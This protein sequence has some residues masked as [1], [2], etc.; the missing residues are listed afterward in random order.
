MPIRKSW[1][2]ANAIKKVMQ[3]V[4]K[5]KKHVL[6]ERRAVSGQL[7]QRFSQAVN[8]VSQIESTRVNSDIEEISSKIKEKHASL[9][10]DKDKPSW[11]VIQENQMELI[12][13][14]I[15][16]LGQ[17][18][19]AA[20]TGTS[21][22]MHCDHV[23]FQVL[24]NLHA[25]TLVVLDRNVTV[26]QMKD[27]EL[28]LSRVSL[29]FMAHVTEREHKI[30][31]Q[32]FNRSRSLLNK[33]SGISPDIMLKSGKRLDREDIKLLKARLD[34]ARKAAGFGVLTK[35]EKEMVIKAV[36]LSAGHWYKCPNGHVY[37]IGECGGAT[38]EG[39]CPDCKTT[40]GGV[41]HSLTAGNAHAADFDNS[42]HAAW[43]E[44]ANMNNFDLRNFIN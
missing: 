8:A 13:K 4:N 18:A 7:E 5:V 33:F 30:A 20:G 16:L 24:K 31:F 40:I 15:E 21:F 2:Y 34:R 22:A 1:R 12:E 27:A 38:Q 19:T 42:R 36:G 32:A 44:A 3:D 29:L 25:V 10:R 23:A 41:N 37:A 28:E 6:D 26:Q 9:Y 17:Y 35:E 39:K 11:D 43:S 14:A